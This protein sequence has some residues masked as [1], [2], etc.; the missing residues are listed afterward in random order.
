MSPSADVLAL[1]ALFRSGIAIEDFQLDPVARALRMPRLDLA[2][3]RT[4]GSLDAWDPGANSTVLTLAVSGTTR[5]RGPRA[6]ERP[7]GRLPCRS[8]I[9]GRPKVPAYP[10]R[11]TSRKASP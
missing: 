6:V 9:A 11:N 2:H 8:V 7:A 3:I 5:L 1:Q 10:C 4:D